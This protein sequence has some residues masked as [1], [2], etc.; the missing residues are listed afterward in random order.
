[1][2]TFVLSAFISALVWC[3][4]ILLKLPITNQ[5]YN[6]IM[7][8]IDTYAKLTLDYG[9]ALEMLD[10]MED[11]DTTLFRITDW[12]YKNILPKEYIEVIKPY[13]V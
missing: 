12:G 13:I 6:K 5:A 10:A 11:F 2:E 3:C 7:S 1:M 4:I 9:L 8:A